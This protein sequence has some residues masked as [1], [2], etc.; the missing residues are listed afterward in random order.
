[1]AR[2][3][4]LQRGLVNKIPESF[5]AEESSLIIPCFTWLASRGIIDLAYAGSEADGCTEYRQ[6]N[7]VREIR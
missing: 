2:M 5:L 3:L 6:K 7:R 1:M 4:T